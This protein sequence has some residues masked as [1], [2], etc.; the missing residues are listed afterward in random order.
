[1]LLLCPFQKGDALIEDEGRFAIIEGGWICFSE[2]KFMDLDASALAK[3]IR[4]TCE[5]FENEM[6]GFCAQRTF[7]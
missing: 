4:S 1:V 3:A 7:P 2:A 6:S 5:S